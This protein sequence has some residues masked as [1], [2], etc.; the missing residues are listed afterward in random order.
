MVFSGEHFQN[1][2]KF[3]FCCYLCR[4]VPIDM[5]IKVMTLDGVTVSVTLFPNILTTN[6][7]SIHVAIV[8]L[9]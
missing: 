7:R 8:W 4:C 9:N 6:E 3:L 5:Y 2:S 1:Q